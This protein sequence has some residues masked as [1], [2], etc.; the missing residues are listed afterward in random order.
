MLRLLSAGLDNWWNDHGP[1]LVKKIRVFQH[2][3]RDML[4]SMTYTYLKA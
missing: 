2:Q 1:R 4:Q 3:L